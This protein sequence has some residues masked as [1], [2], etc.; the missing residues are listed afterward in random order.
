M[1]DLFHMVSHPLVPWVSAGLV[2]LFGLSSWASFRLKL[3]SVYQKLDLASDILKAHLKGTDSSVSLQA[4]DNELSLIEGIKE[5]WAEFRKTLSQPSDAKILA[6]ETPT[7]FF[8]F[9]SLV[10]PQINFHYYQTVPGHLIGLGIVFTFLSFV[11]ALYFIYY[12]LSSPDVSAIQSSL[13]SL[14]NTAILKFSASIA[15]LVSG[16][17]FSF[18]VRA[19]SSRLDA[20][21]ASLCGLLSKSVEVVSDEQVLMNKLEEFGEN[22]ETTASLR[23]LIANSEYARQASSKIDQAIT[24]IDSKVEAL[25]HFSI[26]PV[27]DPVK[28]ELNRHSEEQARLFRE[29]MD[30]VTQLLSDSKFFAPVVAEVNSTIEQLISSAQERL[31]EASSEQNSEHIKLILDNLRL[32]SDNLSKTL[33]SISSKAVVADI[34]ESSASEAVTDVA[35]EQLSV[36]DRDNEKLEII[37]GAIR[38]EITKLSASWQQSTKEVVADTAA[39]HG[40]PISVAEV[41][42]PL[43]ELL[44]ETKTEIKES[45]SFEPVLELIRAESSQLTSGQ[46]EMLDTLS[47][48]SDTIVSHVDKAVDSVLQEL[49]GLIA[50]EQQ[51][52]RVVEPIKVEQSGQEIL[53]QSPAP[54]IDEELIKT[55]VKAIRAEEPESVSPAQLPAPVIDEELIKTVVK[56]IRAEEPEPVSPAQLPA[57]V[58]DEELIKTVVKAVRAEEPESVSPAQ[59]PAPVIDEELIKT[60]VKAVRA[61]E[62]GAALQIANSVSQPVSDQPMSPIFVEETLSELSALSEPEVEEQFEPNLNPELVSIA[63]ELEKL[64]TLTPETV[65]AQVPEEESD[66]PVSLELPADVDLSVPEPVEAA[67]HAVVSSEPASV[68]VPAPAPVDPIPTET[69]SIVTEL[70]ELLIPEPAFKSDGDGSGK[71]PES[72]ADESE[73]KQEEGDILAQTLL[74]DPPSILEIGDEKNTT[75]PA[76]LAGD[77]QSAKIESLIE[78]LLAISGEVVAAASAPVP[79]PVVPPLPKAKQPHVKA[80]PASRG[81]RS[82]SDIK[83][84]AEKSFKGKKIKD[85]VGIKVLGV[86]LDTFAGQNRERYFFGLLIN[87]ASQLSSNTSVATK[88]LEVTVNDLVRN[89]REGG[90]ISDPQEVMGLV[91]LGEQIARLDFSAIDDD[92]VDNLDEAFMGLANFLRG[93][94]SDIAASKPRTKTKTKKKSSP[95]SAP[96]VA[97]IARE[98][99]ITAQELELLMDSFVKRQQKGK[100]SSHIISSPLVAP[101]NSSDTN[102]VAVALE[103]LLHSYDQ[104]KSRQKKPLQAVAVAGAKKQPK[105]EE[106]APTLDSKKPELNTGGSAPDMDRLMSAFNAR[107][108]LQNRQKTDVATQENPQESGEIDMETLLKSFEKEDATEEDL[109]HSDRKHLDGSPF[110]L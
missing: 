81:G 84:W 29:M 82:A 13:N 44:N 109:E 8:N 38:S 62:D 3:A 103:Q 74:Q 79:L 66:K 36:D 73:K 98:S 92:I 106:A 33:E 23:S 50:E 61:E 72:P 35:I 100:R 4:L 110:L 15:G 58:I 91:K 85:G 26:D 20:K 86:N 11:A 71:N 28:E 54:V 104:Q 102:K 89:V 59:L 21:V 24:T 12:G 64:P 49:S 88:E 97:K 94:I 7:R 46:V 60:V 68:V 87:I 101:E 93:Y 17:L 42:E 40:A 99:N 25:A 22:S 77:D 30:S 31:L 52:R 41:V 10:L 45:I 43:R 5:P 76:E 90:S 96:A 69:A 105:A 78:D 107:N 75:L 34:S 1:L 14:L 95:L 80:K 47:Q 39:P 51:E 48:E 83:N 19:N 9:D 65:A 37:L 2:L 63:A 18:S 27:I 70:D 55:V 56:A 32:E 67:T 108:A 16:L 6:T 53:V 57:P